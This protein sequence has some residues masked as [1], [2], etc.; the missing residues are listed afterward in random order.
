[1][2]NQNMLSSD[3]I[4]TSFRK[5]KVSYKEGI[6]KFTKV[7]TDNPRTLNALGERAWCFIHSTESS[8]LDSAVR[9]CDQMLQIDAD[10]EAALY[11]RAVA[12][13]Q[14]NKNQQAIDDL[15]K[16]IHL[17]PSDVNCYRLMATCHTKQHNYKQCINDLTVALSHASD[18]SLR[19]DLFYH[20]ALANDQSGY[21]E[22]ALADVKQGLKADAKDPM[23]TAM[24]AIKSRENGKDE[25][26]P[27]QITSSQVYYLVM[28]DLVSPHDSIQTYTAKI[29]KNPM[30]SLALTMRA[31]CYLAMGKQKQCIEDTN[32]LLRINPRCEAG[33]FLRGVALMGLNNDPEAIKALKKANSLLPDADVNCYLYL[34][35]LNSRQKKSTQSISDATA[36]LKLCPSVSAYQLRAAE[37]LGMDQTA[38]AAADVKQGLQIDPD[39]PSLLE[40]RSLIAGVNSGSKESL[41]FEELQQIV[42]FSHLSNSENID[43]A[44]V[45]IKNNPMNLL[46]LGKRAYCHFRIGREKDFQSVNDDSNK[47]LSISPECPAA[48]YLRAQALIH[49]GQLHAAL[50]DLERLIRQNPADANIYQIMG[51]CHA[52]LK[53]SSLAISDY[54]N[55]IKHT[56]VPSPHLLYRRALL[57]YGQLDTASAKRDID[58]ALR[59]APNDYNLHYSRVRIDI[60]EHDTKQA[61]ADIS[62]ALRNPATPK[63]MYCQ[64][65]SLY[66]DTGQYALVIKDCDVLIASKSSLEKAYQYRAEAY[67]HLKKYRQAIADFE[68]LRASHFGWNG[69]IECAES[70]GAVGQLDRAIHDYSN[71]IVQEPHNVKAYLGRAEIYEKMGKSA[72]VAHD[73]LR[74]R[75][76]HDDFANGKAR[77]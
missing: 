21:S 20:R 2:A 28:R 75:Q 67:T 12:L 25:S 66:R 72:L 50:E 57:Y 73:R 34:A 74:A 61:I 44:T 42:A 15:S 19:R 56:I 58:D 1:M 31:Y 69:S 46:A 76:I 3:E 13:C 14:Q 52:R 64:R 65:A 7:L 77:L 55:A 39:D 22:K 9:D 62:A 11:L 5:D 48:F 43:A 8:A 17:M 47:M 60:D 70:Y 29:R 49:L 45:Q 18:R 33:Y 27:M 59:I 71:V 38:K 26:G 4:L 16:A 35:I 10:C 23:L 41:Q 68:T 63:F 6:R 24:F 53:Q 37:Y 40:L 36:A 32:R 30:D 51:D 54:T